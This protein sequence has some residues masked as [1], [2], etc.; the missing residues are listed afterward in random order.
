MPMQLPTPFVARMRD[1]LRDESD[2]FFE[3]LLEPPPISIRLHHQ[4]GKYTAL[5]DGRVPWCDTGYY[6]PARPPF[7][8]D[9]HWHAGAYYVQEASSMI[10]DEVLR[11]YKPDG[12]SKIWLDLCAAP[13]GKTGI[14]AKHLDPSDTL[15]ANEVVP[16]RR[17]VLYEN[18]VKGGFLH[19]FIAGMQPEDF[20]TSFADVILLDAPCAGEGMMRKEPEAI[21]Q[22]T[23]Q[24][25]TSCAL[26]QQNILQSAMRA[27]KPNGFLIYSTCSYSRNE[28]ISNVAQA[29]ASGTFENL[30]CDFPP[31]WNIA[32]IEEGSA[33][34]Y[35]LFP[36]R[37]RGEG[38]FIAVLRKQEDP[39]RF[40]ESMRK[41]ATA[42]L[43]PFLTD[44]LSNPDE[45]LQVANG[46]D[47]IPVNQK[48]LESFSK[49]SAGLPRAR[50]IPIASIKGR[51]LIPNHFLAMSHLLENTDSVS[52]S[53]AAALDYLER[54]VPV[55]D[56]SLAN[57]WYV[58]TFE[59][60]RLGWLKK[61]S[62]SWKNHYP[63][64]WRLRKRI[65]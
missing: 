3:A 45:W 22:W 28:N 43:H 63:M 9:P 18:L 60:S 15:V 65:L 20:P 51:D 53:T 5:T 42:S 35:Q 62:G 26:L 47:I 2:A 46:E 54:K 58:A 39:K 21:Q 41:L 1:Q 25:V 52:L 57:G 59:D 49:V 36:H 17:T 10:L 24:L 27:L 64:D 29:L 31:E 34:G 6:L 44:T 11:Q 23:P 55:L 7:H 32:T 61:I 19:T 13:G 16:Q 38:L 12:D 33:I 48:A 40:R 37:V 14:L 8:M 50:S 56:A 4:K 30:Q